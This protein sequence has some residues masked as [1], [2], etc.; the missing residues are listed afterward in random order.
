MAEAKKWRPGG[1]KGK[2]HEEMGVPVDK[3]IPAD[4]LRAATHSDD[5]EKRRDAIRAETMK[6]WHHGSTHEERRKAI[7][8]HPRSRRSD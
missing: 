3:K 7:Y 2:L 6:S 4:K 8:K 1:R 5:P